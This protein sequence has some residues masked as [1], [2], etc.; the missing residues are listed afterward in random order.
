MSRRARSPSAAEDAGPSRVER[1]PG[2]AKRGVDSAVDD[3]QA[4]PYLESVMAE[5]RRRL[6]AGLDAY[7]TP[8]VAADAY[9]VRGGA[10][11]ARV[12]A[13]ERWRQQRCH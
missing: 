4:W 13:K 8:R 12:R 10:A 3:A 5:A 6:D 11:E 9:T 2:L 1:D 7:E